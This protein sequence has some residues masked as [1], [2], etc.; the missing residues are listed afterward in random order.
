MMPAPHS[1]LRTLRKL[2]CG[3]AP[4][5][6]DRSRPSWAIRSASDQPLVTI[7]GALPLPTPTQPETLT[8]TSVATSANRSFF[9]GIP[10]GYC[11]CGELN[12]HIAT[13]I[14]AVELVLKSHSTHP[15]RTMLDCP[16]GPSFWC[17]RTQHPNSQH[18]CR[19][20]AWDPN[21]I[22]DQFEGDWVSR[23]S[24]RSVYCRAPS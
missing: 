23:N 14:S 9:I 18:G 21:N 6:A 19:A 12:G 17:M 24:P 11:L 15:N 5:R 7:G 4:A 8:A 10:S 20:G 3:V 13:R 2:D 22:A 1:S 16:R